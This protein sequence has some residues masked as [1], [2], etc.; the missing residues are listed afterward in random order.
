MKRVIAVLLIWASAT[1]VVRAE[2]PGWIADSRTSC[3][4][5]NN[6]PRA[7]DRIA[8]DGPCVDGYAE[9][10][11]VLRWFSGGENYETDVGEFKRG[12]LNGSAVV[13]NPRGRF[14]GVFRNNKP[15]GQGTLRTKDGTIFSGNWSNGCFNEGGRRTFFFTTEAECSI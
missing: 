5:W 8:W 6:Y 3:R 2:P 1:V 14:E 9:G 13:T 4:A 10:R 11:G 12:K 7:D 15:N